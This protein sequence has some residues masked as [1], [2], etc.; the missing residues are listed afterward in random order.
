MN[1]E[2]TPRTCPA[3]GS[4]SPARRVPG[5]RGESS[6]GLQ[7][8]EPLI[9]ERSRPG[10]RAA[11]LPSCDVPEVS[12][13]SVIPSH[14]L[15]DEIPG[16]PEVS[17]P[18]VVRH[19]T[20]LSQWNFGI[21]VGFYPLGS[22]TMKYNPRVNEE[23]ARLPGFAQAHPY[24]PDELCQGAL[25][26]LYEIEQ[27]LCEIS[28]MA[29]VILQPAA[30]AHGEL[31]GM[32][33]IRACLEDR[34]ERRRKVLIPD[35]AHGTNPASSALCGF[36]VVQIASNRQGCL[37]PEAVARAMTPEVAALML[38]N[39]NTLGIFE[40]NILEIAEIIHRQG[41][42]LYCDG[43]NMN[44]LV[45]I[46][47]PADMGFDVIQFNLHKTFS[48]PHGGGGP[49]AGPVGIGQ[50]LTPY[51]PVPT[52][53]REGGFFRRNYDV[54]KTI[55]KLHAFYGNFGVLVRAYAYIR[56][57]GPEGLKRATEVAVLNANY[58]MQ[59]LK[60][61]YDLPYDRL[62]K[63]ECVFSD[64][65]QARHDVHALEI[66]KRLI[67]YG[68]HPPTMYFPLIVKG[69]LM[70]EPTETESKETLDRFIEA[71]KAI[72]REAEES[73]ELVRQAP[74]TT[75]VSKPDETQAARHPVLRWKPGTR[76]PG[77]P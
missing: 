12:P 20:R 45:G 52:I 43:A 10:R 70:I 64:K 71:M 76:N 61:T 53:E 24:L 13:G 8:D 31:T 16:F 63:H 75:R 6:P 74:H 62:C 39:P 49:G 56:T 67:D 21:D 35:S 25:Q 33:L 14:L 51:M 73:P 2:P 46:S 18:E 29:R 22:C 60:G 54:P 41:G 32:M 50:A 11:S 36:D 40:E 48:T 5:R 19:F 69:A 23:A 77:A 59:E 7:F 4:R 38:T 65:N 27:Y 3:P 68:F 55:G 1:P 30:G 17:E 47:R 34:G 9:F 28:G 15:R 66:A 44:A 26:L 58:L 37:D 57:L 72:A 42:L